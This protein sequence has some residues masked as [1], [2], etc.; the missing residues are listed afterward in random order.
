[1]FTPKLKAFVIEDRLKGNIPSPSEVN[2]F[3]STETEDKCARCIFFSSHTSQC[4]LLEM[5]VLPEATCD[6]FLET[7][8]HDAVTWIKDNLSHTINPDNGFP[9]LTAL[10]GSDDFGREDV[11]ASKEE[12]EEEMGITPFEYA[13]SDDVSY[14]IPICRL[15]QEEKERFSLTVETLIGVHIPL[16]QLVIDEKE[17]KQLETVYVKEDV[18]FTPIPKDW[19]INIKEFKYS[20]LKGD[21]LH[22]SQ[23]PDGNYPTIAWELKEEVKSS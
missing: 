17:S 8:K 11:D 9:I 15:S 18:V 23:S 12:E 7:N 10:Y 5:E 3:S 21:K 19:N 6:V 13:F 14:H 20:L 22:L 4:S 2:Y 16:P 1:M